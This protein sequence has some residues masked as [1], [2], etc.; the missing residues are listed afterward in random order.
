MKP[1]KISYTP[2]KTTADDIIQKASAEFSEASSERV[3]SDKALKI[4][5]TLSRAGDIY[6]CIYCLLE[7]NIVIYTVYWN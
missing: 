2:K 6:C 7:L 3:T 5:S 1:G 4:E